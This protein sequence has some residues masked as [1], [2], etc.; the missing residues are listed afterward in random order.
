[1]NVI[2]IKE[3]PC[4]K[5]PP[6]EA[7][8]ENDKTRLIK[9]F[10]FYIKSSQSTTSNTSFSGSLTEHCSFYHCVSLKSD[11]QYEQLNKTNENI[12]LTTEQHEANTV[13]NDRQVITIEQSTKPDESC[14]INNNN[15]DSNLNKKQIPPREITASGS[16]LNSLYK[17][18][19]INLN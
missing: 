18:T 9:K 8:K 15:N 16:S 11:K 17:G 19:G 6:P 14:Y 1:M 4:C 7:K 5:I 2:N 12:L 13:E 3:D 10:K